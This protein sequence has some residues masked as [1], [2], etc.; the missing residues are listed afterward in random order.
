MDDRDDHEEEKAPAPPATASVVRPMA[1]L[2]PP[3]SVSIA[4]SRG[5]DAPALPSVRAPTTRSSSAQSTTTGS[6]KREDKSRAGSAERSPGGKA[7][8]ADTPSKP[9]K[10]YKQEPSVFTHRI[11]ELEREIAAVKV[12]LEAP[13]PPA[14]AQSRQ[15]AAECFEM[16]QRSAFLNKKL[17][18][19][20]HWTQR[21][22]SLMESAPLLEIACAVPA[23]NEQQTEAQQHDC[24]PAGS[25]H[26]AHSSNTTSG[27]DCPGGGCAEAGLTLSFLDE[28]RRSSSCEPLS[29][30]ILRERL[31]VIVDRSTERASSLMQSYGLAPK[32]L[33]LFPLQMESRGWHLATGVMVDRSVAF[34]CERVLPSPSV[35]RVKDIATELWKPVVRDEVQ[36][37]FLPIVQ[38]SAL[39]YQ[40]ADCCLWHHMLQFSTSATACAVATVGS[41]QTIHDDQGSKRDEWQISIE[42][43]HDNYLYTFAADAAGDNGSG[44]SPRSGTPPAGSASPLSALDLGSSIRKC[45]MSNNFVIGLRVTVTDAGVK[46]LVVGSAVFDLQHVRDPAPELL[47]YLVSYLPIYEE[48]YLQQYADL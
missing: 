30:F 25:A 38:E 22:S 47:Q 5:G 24:C 44:L 18:E 41:F 1:K 6:M 48:L 20:Y 14:L 7:A 11:A 39:A 23:G 19:H 10:R 33:I 40:D 46:L 13:A 42:T 21:V 16:K 3:V 8:A 43:A 29:R 28:W 15:L 35:A 34:R 37:T 32:A 36:R 4:Q 27:K 12:E 17:T 31:K 2:L 9:R 26:C 45:S